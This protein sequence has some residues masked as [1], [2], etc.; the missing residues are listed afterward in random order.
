M[1][2]I[3]HVWPDNKSFLTGQFRFEPICP[4]TQ[5]LVIFFIVIP[6]DRSKSE[7]QHHDIVH[8]WEFLFEL[9]VDKRCGSII[10][11]ITEENR[12][13]KFKDPEKVAKLWGTYKGVKRM[14][15]EKLSRAL[16]M[17]YSKGIIVKVSR[18]E[19]VSLPESVHTIV[20]IFRRRLQLTFPVI[21]MVHSFSPSILIFVFKVICKGNSMNASAIKELQEGKIL[22]KLQ[23]KG[24]FS[25]NCTSLWASAL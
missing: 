25:P 16:R 15:Y 1:L 6:T 9:L 22:S 11:W 21:K 2:I 12:E 23:G 4:F 5:R 7:P 20:S 14:N 3:S 24:K 10:T 8:L 13:F 17:Y 18:I 19:N